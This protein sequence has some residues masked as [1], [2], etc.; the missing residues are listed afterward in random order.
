[1]VI[2]GLQSA[3]I[4]FSSSSSSTELVFSGLI[5]GNNSHFLDGCIVSQ[6]H[7]QKP[8]LFPFRC[9]GIP[10]SNALKNLHL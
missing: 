5:C 8:F 1:L 9:R 2:V 10:Y 6:K 4:N 3:T 7:N